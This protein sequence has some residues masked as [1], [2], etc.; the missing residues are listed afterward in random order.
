MSS[1]LERS[2][3]DGERIVAEA[4][5]HWLYTFKALLALIIPFIVLIIILLFGRA[6]AGGWPIILGMI[7][8]LAGIV[9]F[10]R[11]MLRRWTTEIAVTSHRFVEKSGLVS[12]RTNEIALTNIEG[13][14]VYQGIWGRIWG[15]GSLRIEGTGID[16][17]DIPPIADPVG[18]RRAI[19]T[20]KGIK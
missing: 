15:Y 6:F 5:F 17:V 11:R 10:L 7:L 9:I 8:M 13:V 1:Y 4:H 14:R 20:A 12:L 2:L 16:K 18:F 19:E 3:G